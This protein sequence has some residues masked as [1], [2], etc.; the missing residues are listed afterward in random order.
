MTKA[1]IFDGD[2][3]LWHT[4]WL[5]DEARSQAREIVEEAGL[6][7][8]RWEAR[9]RLIDVENVKRFGHS[10]K[11]F[12]TSCIEA[13]EEV[14]TAESC[15]IDDR[16]CKRIREAA[17]TAF[18]RAAPLIESARPTL[19]SLRSRGFLLALLTKGDPD[20]QRRR[21]EQ[22]GLASLFHLVEIVREKTPE[23]ILSTLS[24]LGVDVVE[25]LSVG[26]SVRSD[27]LPSLK[28]G[29]TPVWIDAHVWEYEH[30]HGEIPLKNVIEV[31]DLS[32]LLQMKL[33]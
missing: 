24:R 1:I 6:D 33:M 10:S 12:P 9:E 17:G 7:G 31:K 13:Y 11:R 18:T 4:E 27:V 28:A 22:S 14:C 29:V 15:P 32:D 21:V 23:T 20:I 2:D 3:T 19:E 16:T 25:A 5:Y 30:D 26:N 8:E